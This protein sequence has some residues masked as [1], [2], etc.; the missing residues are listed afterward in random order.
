MSNLKKLRILVG[1]AL[2]ALVTI[3]GFGTVWKVKHHN[4]QHLVAQSRISNALQ[5]Q[6]TVAAR[7]ALPFLKG[8]QERTITEREI[9]RLELEQAL[10]WKD[11]EAARQI[12]GPDGADFLSAGQ[13]ERTALLLARHEICTGIPSRYRALR[14]EWKQKTSYPDQWFLLD[15]DLRV[16]AGRN[17]AARALL[18]SRQLE[19]A[20][21]G[22]R[23]A[24][25]ALLNAGNPA[26]ALRHLNLGLKAAPKHPDLLSFRAQLHERAGSPQR[27]RADFV[28][29]VLADQG[30]PYH[31]DNLAQFYL[32]NGEPTLAVETW[33]S[34]MRHTGLGVY[35]FKAWF[36]SKLTT[37]PLPMN[38]LRSNDPA[39]NELF[40]TMETMAPDVFF[41]EAMADKL[42]EQRTELNRSEFQWLEFLSL[43][44]RSI[45]NKEALRLIANGEVLDNEASKIHPTLVHLVRFCA[46]AQ[47]ASSVRDVEKLR[48][49]LHLD[50]QNK[51]PFLVELRRWS[52]GEMTATD[53]TK[54]TKWL[55]TPEAITAAFL[56]AGWSGPA[57]AVGV[58][59][60]FE[61]SQNSPR[62][63]DQHYA[64]ALQIKRGNHV[65]LAWLKKLDTRSPGAD[66]LA[67]ELLFFKGEI[68]EGATLLRSVQRLSSQFA[69]EATYLLAAQALRVG[70]VRA[71]R[72]WIFQAELDQE[73]K[74]IEVLAQTWLL[75][76]DEERATQCYL[77][78]TDSSTQALQYL[79]K[80]ALQSHQWDDAH[81]WTHQ[82]VLRAP[83]APHYR[84]RLALI[85]QA[86][87]RHKT[88][89]SKLALVAR[90]SN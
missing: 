76:G 16:S 23:Q 4:K 67:G 44:R 43:V 19:G 36:W 71:A 39:W 50:S 73:T 41:T 37:A 48:A 58:G 26:L 47:L 10:Q 29:A 27:A 17:A 63:L 30:N 42:K 83:E 25:L 7:E 69:N 68:E 53:H 21:E 57:L 56:A 5:I 46:N 66:L 77:R 9:R 11:A 12:V 31:R 80:K 3:G 84:E 8:E 45:D 59:S 13:L 24:R 74:G 15:A 85:E 60:D 2:C 32:R 62:W 33:L 52:K 1:A 89:P 88:A 40:A 79:S 61:P 86:M 35:G 28:S 54:Y 22:D 51:H 70:R 49:T 34:T 81:K 65:A 38:M 18:R 82:L 90:K 6:D 14:D 78:I 55:Q 87:E 20:E 75:E 72:L 64:R